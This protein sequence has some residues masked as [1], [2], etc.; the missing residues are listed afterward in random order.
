MIFFLEA[1]SRDAQDTEEGKPPLSSRDL[2]WNLRE[3]RKAA[4]ASANVRLG[5]SNIDADRKQ[6]TS[7]RIY[8]RVENS[9][10]DVGNTK[11]VLRY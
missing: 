6:P 5:L 2:A 4:E 3:K 1:E 11:I 10:S 9:T 7:T 8:P